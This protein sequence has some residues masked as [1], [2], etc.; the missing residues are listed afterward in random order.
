MYEPSKKK[1]QQQKIYP[2]Q[3][4]PQGGNADANLCEHCSCH[5]APQTDSK[6]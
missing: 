3:Y 4:I 6:T 5:T 2:T 1:K